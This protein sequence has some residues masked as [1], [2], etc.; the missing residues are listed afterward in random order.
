MHTSRDA[1]LFVCQQ[2]VLALSDKLN[3][4]FIVLLTTAVTL[5]Y[6]GVRFG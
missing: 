4:E 6:F 2:I 1:L 3:R 5:Q